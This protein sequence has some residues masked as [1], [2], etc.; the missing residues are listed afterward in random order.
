MT[1]HSMFDCG[2]YRLDSSEKKRFQTN[3]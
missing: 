1:S 2:I 3:S